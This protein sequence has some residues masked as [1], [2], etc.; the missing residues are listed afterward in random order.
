MLVPA[1]MSTPALRDA[2]SGFYDRSMCRSTVGMTQS[3]L[4]LLRCV[5]RDIQPGNDQILTGGRSPQ[6]RP[7]LQSAEDWK[8]MFVRHFWSDFRG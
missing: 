3:L 5:I 7:G 6:V 4:I 2:A 1:V 8:G